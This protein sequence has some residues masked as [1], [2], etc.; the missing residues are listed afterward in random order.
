[1]ENNVKRTPKWLIAVI[2]IVVIGVIG[3]LLGGGKS[4]KNN[5]QGE[6]K[7]TFSGNSE[8][9][10]TASK[11]NEYGFNETFKFDDLEITIG[12]GYTFTTVKNQFSEHNNQ[13][14]IKLP[15]TVKNPTSDTKGLNMFYYKVYGSKGTE[16]STLDAYFDSKTS[17]TYG[18]DLRSGAGQTYYLYVQYDGDG[19]Y[20][21]EFNNYSEKVTAEFN[22]TK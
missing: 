2:I 16:V 10:T 1:M 3:S 22:I 15:V 20:A 17:L 5:N 21:I 6:T 12:D 9:T 14:T 11:K 8:T 19:L 18:G 4:D 13:T 7:Y